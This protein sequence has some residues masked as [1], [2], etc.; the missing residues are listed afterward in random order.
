MPSSIRFRSL[1]IALAFSLI[2]GWLSIGRPALAR[3]ATAGDMSSVMEFDRS[4]FV[5]KKDGRWKMKREYL[6]RIVNDRGRENESVQLLAYNGKAQRLKVLEAS[7]YNGDRAQKVD[8]KNIEIKEVGD[9][10]K[11]F[12]PQKQVQISFPSVQVGSKVYVRYEVEFL[13][14]PVPGF[15]STGYVFDGSYIESLEIRVRSELP[16]YAWTN[17]KKGTLEIGKGEEPRK[18]FVI[19]TLKPIVEQVVQEEAPYQSPERSLV[20]VLTSQKDWNQ[21]GK[22][23]VPKFEKLLAQPLTPTLNAI[24]VEAAKE[25]TTL[26]RLN[27]VTASVSQS[28]RYFGDWRRR[29]GG[30]VPRSLSEIEATR[31]GDC[32]DFSLVTAA[33]YRALGYKADVAIVWR[34]WPTP[35]KG[36]YRWPVDNFFNHAVTRVEAEGKVHWI[37]G[38]NPVSY[39]REP[40]ADIS[41]RPAL[42]LGQ[43]KVF[44]DDVP[45]L[46]PE[47]YLS[48]TKLAYEL[49]NDRTVK[50]SGSANL[51]GRASILLTTK[52]F[53]A[54]AS[55]TNYEIIRAMS[56]YEKVLDASVGEY[57]RGTRIVKD[58][59][60]PVEFRLTSIGLATSAGFGFPLMREPVVDSVLLETKD[61][62]SSIYLD[63][64]G[65]V[66]NVI[67]VRNVRRIG[68]ISLDCDLSSEWMKLKRR[69]K[70]IERGVQIEDEVRI[71]KTV[72]PS[73]AFTSP[74]F[75]DFQDR[76]RACFHRAAV[77]LEARNR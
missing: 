66:R 1:R 8:L 21:Y 19:R 61:R 44:L 77:I 5:I 51:K 35:W 28:F 24:K 32:K 37:D 72:I 68:K 40:F 26:E 4:E 53:Y 25:K 29:N 49:E 45:E 56:N 63:V 27:K 20:L 31:Y 2:V 67:E 62:V 55:T 46:N 6:L 14:T 30:F 7:T 69:V 48:E 16:I 60:I 10:A 57:D 17:D 23:L 47:Y 59:S 22:T 65:V 50:V 70:D 18:S 42:V 43:D 54:P 3:L 58:L 39:A 52:S 13:E 74:A 76:A 38:T 34:G 15:W 41:G 11:G 71:D 36:S 9:F 73:D 12:D 33:I 64:P 75:L